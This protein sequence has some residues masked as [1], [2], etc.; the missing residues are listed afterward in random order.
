M[1]LI[2]NREKSVKLVEV[3]VPFDPFISNCYQTKFNKYFPISQE[4]NNLGFRTEILVFIVG[5]LG[6]VHKRFNSGLSKLNVPNYEINSL[7]KYCSISAILG[8]RLVWKMRCR[9]NDP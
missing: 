3:S 9:R 8:S 1:V 2:N 5:S 6:H 4:I 7:S